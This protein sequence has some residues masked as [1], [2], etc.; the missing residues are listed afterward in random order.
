MSFLA[1]IYNTI[2]G[3]RP[4]RRP[5]TSSFRLNRVDAYPQ[6]LTYHPPS[7]TTRT[8]VPLPPTTPTPLLPPRTLVPTSQLEETATWYTV[9]S[10]Q[11]HA[12][13]EEIPTLSAAGLGL[14]TTTTSPFRATGHAYIIHPLL[15]TE[16]RG[17]SVMVL[18]ELRRWIEG[19]AQ[20]YVGAAKQV[21]AFREVR[22]ETLGLVDRELWRRGKGEGGRV[23]LDAREGYLGVWVDAGE[24][25]DEDSEWDDGEI[26]METL[27]QGVMQ[28]PMSP[29]GTLTAVGLAAADAMAAQMVV[30]LEWVDV[31][32][33]LQD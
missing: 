24:V 30:N 12:Y 25:F 32:D 27:D 23:G 6:L 31:L 17:M 29:S 15:P 4:R 22:A 5:R 33:T 21:Q 11:T 1:D 2:T 18:E 19:S 3:S 9:T 16:V 8:S 7:T 20:V 28:L 26:E 10:A 14:S 13:Y